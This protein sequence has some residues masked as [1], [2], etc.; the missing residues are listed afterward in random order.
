MSTDIPMEGMPSADVGVKYVTRSRS[1]A[2]EVTN[3]NH[4]KS[5]ICVCVI[6]T[7]SLGISWHGSFTKEELIV[8]LFFRNLR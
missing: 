7:I 5:L 1:I 6:V 4:H 3:Q 8:M 2:R